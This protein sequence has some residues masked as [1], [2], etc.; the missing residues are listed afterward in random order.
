MSTVDIQVALNAALNDFA[1]T[2][3]ITVSWENVRFDARD[4]DEYLEA[5]TMFSDKEKAGIATNAPDLYTGIYQ[6]NLIYE[7]ET[8]WKPASV[9][10]DLILEAFYPGRRLMS[11]KLLI[12]KSIPS[13]GPPRDNRYVKIVSIYW[14]AIIDPA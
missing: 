7:A 12:E 4:K 10:I 3:S 2:N 8:S 9:I 6:I 13:T 11:N 1:D 5:F 14:R